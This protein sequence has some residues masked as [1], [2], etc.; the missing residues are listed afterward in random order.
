MKNL[1]AGSHSIWFHPGA[2]QDKAVL[3]PTVHTVYQRPHIS[4]TASQH[5]CGKKANTISVHTA[6]L[7]VP[8]VA[9]FF[10]LRQ[11]GHCPK[12]PALPFGWCKRFITLNIRKATKAPR[13]CASESWIAVSNESRKKCKIKN[14]IL[15]CA[16][17]GPQ[18]TGG[19]SAGRTIHL[20]AS[21]Y[22]CG[23]IVFGRIWNAE[24]LWHGCILTW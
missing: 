15:H 7:P 23:E 12:P 8:Q 2:Q 21:N 13:F 10:P 22:R 11:Q 17:R 3:I 1:S 18:I 16:E 19:G 6:S 24:Q 9:L 20:P 14:I 5:S 4:H